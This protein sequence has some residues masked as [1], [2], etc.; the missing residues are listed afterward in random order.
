MSVKPNIFGLFKV[1]D[2]C[3]VILDKTVCLVK[4]Q[5]VIFKEKVFGF[6]VAEKRIYAVVIKAAI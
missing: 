2:I 1:K 3:H 4:Q 5:N 6:I